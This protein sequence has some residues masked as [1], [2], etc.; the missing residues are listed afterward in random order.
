MAG[1]CN[2][3]KCLTTFMR[4]TFCHKLWWCVR[5]ET[6]TSALQWF[7]ESLWF[8]VATAALLE[9]LWG[10]AV[11]RWQPNLER[12]TISR[13]EI[14]SHHYPATE[15]ESLKYHE[16]NVALIGDHVFPYS[17]SQDS[18][19]FLVYCLISRIC[20]LTEKIGNEHWCYNQ[21]CLLSA[22]HHCTVAYYNRLIY[23]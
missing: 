14:R 15:T 20:H 16:G 2:I 3:N 7:L 8:S 1:C 10:F 5:N 22:M 13:S 21:S 9:A 18:Q 19:T 11:K 6:I 4:I 17:P 12:K 23:P